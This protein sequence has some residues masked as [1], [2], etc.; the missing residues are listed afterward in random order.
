MY[1]SY[2]LWFK[3]QGLL[4]LAGYPGAASNDYQAFFHPRFCMP[5]PVELERLLFP[6]LP[7][8]EEQVR[9]MGTAASASRRAFLKAMHYGIVVTVQDA[10]ELAD[11]APANPVHRLLLRNPCFRYGCLQIAAITQDTICL[12]DAHAGMHTL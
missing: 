10:L 8:L 11:V 9:A 2:L 6:K 7:Q 1:N 3:P 5:V 4:G 12:V